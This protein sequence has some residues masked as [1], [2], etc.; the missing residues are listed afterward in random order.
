MTKTSLAR[1][2]AVM[3]DARDTRHITIEIATAKPFCYAENGYQ[4]YPYKNSYGYYGTGGIG[5]CLPPQ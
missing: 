5:V 2:Q 4:Q 1:F 3:N